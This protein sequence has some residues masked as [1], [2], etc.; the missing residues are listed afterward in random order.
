M[1]D[2]GRPRKFDRHEALLQAMNIFWA[3]GYEGTQL[4][5]LT[6]AMGI[7]PPSFYAAFGSKEAAFRE[8]VELYE[9]TVAAGPLRALETNES[10]REAIRA[11]LIGGVDRAG[12]VGCMM[13]L[14]VVNCLPAN[15][16]LRALLL[17]IRQRGREA[18]RRRLE[19]GVREGDIP[20]DTDVERL[21]TFY[22]AIPQAISLQARDGASREQ[23][24]D[25]VISAMAA[26][27]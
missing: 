24:E 1:A 20:P 18:I 9:A 10:T 8:A 7:N 25:V 6:A 4:T 5:D 13:M 26:L 21:T 2:R 14:G 23:L 22:S 3:K 11:M 16:P 17:S 19:R 15:E 12:S 27:G